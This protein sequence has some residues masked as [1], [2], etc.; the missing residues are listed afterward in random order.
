MIRW[1]FGVPWYWKDQIRLAWKRGLPTRSAASR[2][3]I[4][5]WRFFHSPRNAS[6]VGEA[7]NKRRAVRMPEVCP[8]KYCSIA[9]RIT[10]AARSFGKPKMPV[11]R[12]GNEMEVQP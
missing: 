3:R 7:N 1:S 10:L 2:P 6:T 5:H 11:E 9:E 4:H 8:A 12:A